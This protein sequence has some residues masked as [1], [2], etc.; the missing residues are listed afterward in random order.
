MLDLQPLVA[1]FVED[2]LSAIRSASLDELRELLTPGDEPEPVARPH[3][4]RAKPSKPAVKK[5]PVEEPAMV[6]EITDPELLLGAVGRGEQAPSAVP[7]PDDVGEP[8][9]STERLT[10]NRTA[11]LREG[12]TLARSDGA[13]TVIRRAKRS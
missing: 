13:A 9:R 3:A 4:R 12:E 1:R 5:V 11:A 7:P 10:V 6:A 8:P 2:V